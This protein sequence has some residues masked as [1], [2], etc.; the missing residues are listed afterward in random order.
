MHIPI[1]IIHN[2]CVMQICIDV[3]HAWSRMYT[4]R[5]MYVLKFY[6]R[7]TVERQYCYKQGGYLRN[8]TTNCTGPIVY[9]YI[10]L[11]LYLCIHWDMYKRGTI[12]IASYVYTWS[13][14]FY[15]TASWVQHFGIGSCFYDIIILLSLK[16]DNASQFPQL[17]A[18]SPDAL[19]YN[20]V[21][22]EKTI[23][24]REPNPFYFY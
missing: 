14:K 16:I 5:Y 17:H 11:Y 19:Q 15:D 23:S 2:K 8:L 18:W 13:D 22:S 12:N 20:A 1:P 24:P 21:F 7:V 6:T 10:Y 9:I 3:H 4:Y